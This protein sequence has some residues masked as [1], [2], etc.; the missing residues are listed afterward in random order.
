M[1]AIWATIVAMY[2]T[3]SIAAS[4][5]SG[6]EACDQAVASRQPNPA[7]YTRTDFRRSEVT[8][9]RIEV[10]QQMRGVGVRA[11][12]IA[13]RLAEYDKGTFRPRILTFIIDFQSTKPD[14]E[15]V[16]K[17]SQCVL[18]LNRPGDAPSASLAVIDGT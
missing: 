3:T 9:S 8:L 1:R 11:E 13:K 17:R 15:L 4:I 2:A 7:L 16:S 12:M 18:R 6:I 14:G 10:E 5:D